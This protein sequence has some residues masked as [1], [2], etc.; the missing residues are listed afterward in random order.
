MEN[1]VRSGLPA[2]LSGAQAKILQV[3]V[4]FADRTGEVTISYVGIA[5]YAG[6]ASF[7]TVRK[8]LLR[9]QQLHLLEISPKVSC[10]F[11]ECSSYRLTVDDPKFLEIIRERSDRTQELV[12]EQ[13][14]MRQAK[15]AGRRAV[16]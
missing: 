8:A 14:A 9:F 16:T 5:Q 13:R 6:V 15:R 12:T 1:F 3:L 11:R 4:G 7:S 10:G 2:E